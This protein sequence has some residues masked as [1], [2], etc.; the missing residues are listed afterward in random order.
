MYNHFYAIDSL[1]TK[2]RLILEEL[3]PSETSDIQKFLKNT[4]CYHDLD[5]WI[6]EERNRQ[7]T[8]YKKYKITKHHYNVIKHALVHPALKLSRPIS[9]LGSTYTKI[10]KNKKS[11]KQKAFYFR[12]L[13]I[14]LTN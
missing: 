12:P 6:Y 4:K 14:Y 9:V 11:K 13:K 5:Q 3:H 1:P 8:F 7:R 2:C 10:L